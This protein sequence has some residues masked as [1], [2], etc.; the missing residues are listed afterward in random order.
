MDEIAHL[1]DYIGDLYF[2]FVLF[3]FE[4]RVILVMQPGD[5][6]LYSSAHFGG[7]LEEPG[8]SSWG[9]F[10][11]V[12]SPFLLFHSLKNIGNISVNNCSVFSNFA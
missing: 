8:D 4:L 6:V 7:L 3:C 1:L 10:N 11:M 12:S 9:R 2:C 5:V